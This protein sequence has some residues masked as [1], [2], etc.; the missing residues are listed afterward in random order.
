MSRV[1]SIHEYIL[2]KRVTCEQ[3]EKAIEK[4]RNQE[5]FNLPGLT[6]HYFLKYIRGSRKVK[7]A[8]IWIYQDRKSWEKLWGPAEKPVKKENYPVKWKIWENDI[9]EPLLAQDPNRIYYTAFEEL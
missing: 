8:A 4:A 2:K 5:L 1:I 3:F 9:L 7:Y 6:A